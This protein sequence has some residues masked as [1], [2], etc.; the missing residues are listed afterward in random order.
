[1]IHMYTYLEERLMRDVDALLGEFDISMDLYVYAYVCNDT[2]IY[3]LM[4]HMY[5]Y[6]E[7]RLMRVG[8]VVQ[9]FVCIY[10]CVCITL[11]IYIYIYCICA[12]ER[13]WARVMRDFDALLG[14]FSMYLCVYIYMHIGMYMYGIM[15]TNIYIYIL[16]R[17]M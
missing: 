12:L 8:C 2:H 13:K 14:E 10:A 15:Y 1:M 5:T 6:L 11:Y 9:I 7:E 16:I 3:I 4:I 17:A